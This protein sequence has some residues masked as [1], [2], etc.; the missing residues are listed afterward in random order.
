MGANNGPSTNAAAPIVVNF[1]APGIYPYEFD[2]RSGTGGALSLS[3]TVTQAGTT[4]GLRPVE[5]LV[6]TSSSSATP[7]V[8]QPATFTVLA[9]D[10]TG[11]PIP[12]VV[13]TFNVNGANARTS[14]ATTDSTGHAALTYVGGTAGVD[15]IQAVA[16]IAGLPGVS[17][18]VPVLWQPAQPPQNPNAPQITAS[19]TSS[20]QLPATGAYTA[21]VTDPTGQQ[22]PHH[23]ELDPDWR[24][25]QRTDRNSNTT[26]HRRHLS[27][28]WHL[29][30]ADHCY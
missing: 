5:T 10:E 17:N 4:T 29:H 23:R 12:N 14:P 25:R 11:V 21:T 26:V 15:V 22:R 2:Y 1:P 20:V 7:A 9:K 19:G 27:Y 8:G 28:C 18:Q 16:T 24:P 3:V 6:L 13:I 30:A